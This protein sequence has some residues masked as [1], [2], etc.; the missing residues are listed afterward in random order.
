VS[1]A[2]RGIEA[3]RRA[4]RP[5]R[6][7]QDVLDRAGRAGG[8]RVAASAVHLLPN[9]DEADRRL[10]RSRAVA[11]AA[12]PRRSPVRPEMVANHIVIV[13]GRV[14]GGWR[15]LPGKRAMVVETA[16]ATRLDGAAREALR[17]AAARFANFLGLPVTLRARPAR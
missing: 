5:S 12:W 9:Y 10:P 6:G 8:A 17:A 11:G 2:R 3:R 4:S 14:V 15:R 1:D 16:L 7:R 13:A